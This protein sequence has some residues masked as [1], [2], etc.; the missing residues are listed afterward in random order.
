MTNDHFFTRSRWLSAL[1]IVFILTLH[2]M[3]SP[4]LA[5][6]QQDPVIAGVNATATGST[7]I[8]VSALLTNPDSVSATVY[9]RYKEGDGDWE[10]T[11]SATTSGTSATFSALT[12]LKPN[13]SY[14]IQVALEE[15]DSAFASNSA[16]V[17]TKQASLGS[18]SVSASANGTTAGTVAVT[19]SF[20]HSGV[21]VY[22]QHKARSASWPTDNATNRQ[23]KAPTTTGASEVLSFS[24]TG[25]THSTQYDVRASLA[26]DFSSGVITDD[27]TTATPA[28]TITGV[29]D[30][31]VT[32]NSAKITVSVSNPSSTEVYARYKE[33]SKADSTYTA[34]TSKPTTTTGS[35][36]DVVFSLSG[37]SDETGYTVQASLASDYSGA[38][39]DTFTTLKTPPSITSVGETAYDHNSATITVSVS[40]PNGTTV[41]LQ[42]KLNTASWPA[43]DSDQISTNRQS[44]PTQT[45]NAT[46]NLVFSITGLTAN[47]DYDVRVSFVADFSSGVSTDSFKTRMTPAISGMSIGSIAY[48]SATATVSLNNAHN[49]TVYVRHKVKGAA[50][51]TYVSTSQT[52]SASSAAFTL[53]NGVSPGKTYVVQTSLVSGYGSGV[54]EREFT[55]PGISSVSVSDIEYD[56]VKATV[57]VSG[58]TTAHSSTTVYLQRKAS[59]ESSWSPSTPLQMNA[60]STNSSLEFT[61]T[62][63]TPGKTYTVRS[64][65]NTAFAAGLATSS[66]FT[67]PSI[68]SVTVSEVEHNGSKVTVTVAGMTANTEDTVVYLGYKDSDD[69]TYTSAGTATATSTD[70]SLEFTLSG[71]AAGENYTVIAAFNSAYTAGAATATFTT[72]SISS[73]TISSISHGGATATVAV[74]GMASNTE[75]TTVYLQFKA[76]DEVSWSPSTP[77]QIDATSSDS[78]LEYTLTGLTAGK[79]YTV[80]AAFN[81]GFTVSLQSTTFT[82]P[83]ISSVSVSDRTHKSAKVT[84]AVA[85]MTANTNNTT[86]YFQHQ[87][88]GAATWTP[89][90]P[91]SMTATSSAASLEFPLSGLTAG[92]TYNVR[93]AFN[94][95]FSISLQ[96]AAF[97]TPNLSIA[98]PASDITHEAAKVRVTVSNPDTTNNTAVYLQYKKTADT[99]FIS[100]GSLSATSSSPTVEFSLSSLRRFT[101]YDVQASFESAFPSGDFTKS[102][103]FKTLQ[104]FPD[105]PK[106]FSFDQTHHDQLVISWEAP[107][108]DGG[109][110]VTGYKVQWRQD[111]GS[112]SSS[113]QGAT[114]ADT[115][116]YSIEGLASNTAYQV[117]VL[118]VNAIGDTQSPPEYAKTTRQAPVVSAVSVPEGG[119]DKSKRTVATATVTLSHGDTR[120]DNQIFFR[121]AVDSTPT[122]ASATPGSWTNLTSQSVSGSTAN[123]TDDFSLTGLTG[124]THYVVQSSLD[125]S[126]AAGSFAEDRFRTGSVSPS[127][128]QNVEVVPGPVPRTLVVRWDAPAS[129]GGTP[130]LGYHVYWEQ[131]ETP[132]EFISDLTVGP[133][134]FER[135][136]STVGD[137]ERWYGWVFA[138]N[139]HYDA[140]NAP[141]EISPSS[142]RVLGQASVAPGVPVNFIVQSLNGAINV[143]WGAAPEFN[144]AVVDYKI[145]VRKTGSADEPTTV[146]ADKLDGEIL[147]FKTIDGF[148]NGTE[149]EVRVYAMD[150]VGRDGTPTRWV[151]VIPVGPIGVPASVTATA[152][153][154]KITVTWQAPPASAGDTP[155]GYT[156]EWKRNSD[157][158]WSE[159]RGATSPHEIAALDGGTTYN[160]RV[161][162]NVRLNDGSPSATINVVPFTHPDAPAIRVSPANEALVVSWPVPFNGGSPIKNY[163][164]QWTETGSEFGSTNEATVTSNSHRI[165]GLT[166]GAEYQVRAYAVNEQD[167]TSEPS[168][169]VT[170]TPSEIITPP[171]PPPSQTPGAPSS[172]LVTAGDE[173]LLVTWAIPSNTGTSAITGYVVQWTTGGGTFGDDEATTT[174]LEYTVTGLTNDTEYD[175]RV[176][177]VNSNGRGTPSAVQSETPAEDVP[178]SISAI[179]VPGDDITETEA[180]IEISIANNDDG[181]S[182]D[183]YLR[184]RIY[185]PLGD[186]SETLEDSS[187]AESVEFSLAD[188]TAN[189]EYEVQASLDDT[190]PTDDTA[191]A[192]FTTATT[193]PGAPQKV[194]VTPMNNSLVVKWEAPEDD[195]GAEITDYVVQWKSGEEEFSSDREA[196]V[197][198]ETLTYTIADLEN[199]VEYTV[200]VLAMNENG[201]SEPSDPATGTP[202]DTSTG[203]IESVSVESDGAT[204][205]NVS[206]VVLGADEDHPVTVYMRHRVKPTE[207]DEENATGNGMSQVQLASPQQE[208]TEWSE[209]QSVETTT[210]VAEFTI[211]DLVEDAVYEIQVSLEDTFVDEPSIYIE[212]FTPAKVPGAPENLVLMSGDAEIIAKWTAP[213]D[214]G[215]SPVTGYIVRWKSGTEDFDAARQADVAVDDLMHTITGLENGTE[216]D[217]VVV[218]VNIIGESEPSA[219][220]SATPT[221]EV[222]TTVVRVR[223]LD[224][225]QT[226]ANVEVTLAN[227]D[228]SVVTTVHLRYRAV[229]GQQSWTEATPTAAT[230]DVL[231]FALIGLTPNTQYEVQASLD[232]T[233][234]VDAVKS[235]TFNTQSVPQ[236]PRITS[237]S[238]FSVNEGETRV[239]TLT[240][241]DADTPT[242]QLVWSILPSS[243]DGGNFM[244]SGSGALFFRSAK[245]FENPDDA[246]RDGTYELT[247]QVSDGQNTDTAMIRVTL[248]DV[249]E[250]T[251][252]PTPSPTPRPSPTPGPTPSPTPT[253]TP[254]P[255]AL[256][257]FA[258]ASQTVSEGGRISITVRLSSAARKLLA[259]P[260]RIVAGGTAEAGDYRISGLANGALSFNIGQSVKAF[261]FAASEDAD[262]NNE[263]VRLGFGALPEGVSAG[264]QR[265][266]TVT[267]IDNDVPVTGGGSGGSSISRRN[268]PP[269]FVERYNAVRSVAENTPAGTPVGDPVAAN[270]PDS[271]DQNSLNYTIAGVDVESFSIESTSGQILTK[272]ELNFETKSEYRVV[273]LV[274]DGR[275]GK[276]SISVTIHVTDINEPPVILGDA[277]ID[278]IENST[279]PVGS[280]TAS[281]PEGETDL[282][283]S[284][285]GDDSHLFSIGG[286]GTLRFESAPDFES[287]AD[288]DGDNVYAVT[289]QS[290][291]ELGVG[292]LHIAISVTDADDVGTVTLSADLP[293]VGSELN[294]RLEEQDGGVADIIWQWERSV[295]GSTWSSIPGAGSSSYTPV[296]S[297][298]G[299]HLRAIV[300]YKD[301]HGP[302]KVATAMVTSVVQEGPTATPTPVP[303]REPAPVP[304]VAPT[305]VPAAVPTPVPTV[306]PDAPTATPTATPVSAPVSMPA[307]PPTATPVVPAPV[308]AVQ[309]TATAVPATAVPIAPTPPTG[310]MPGSADEPT[311]ESVEVGPGVAPGLVIAL[312]VAAIVVVAIT[313]FVVASRRR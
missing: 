224:A 155:T 70:S 197:D 127:V 48:N 65:F 290:S 177:A 283:W 153:Q 82:T 302:D 207:E 67:T 24:L 299:R 287:A 221:E 196:K 79:T 202:S 109:A 17:I 26:D 61:L 40:N 43:S 295:D 260:V 201:L 113:A 116:E 247:V 45:T 58:L 57:A 198:D 50:D 267:I 274:R 130:I 313:A 279:A 51:S 172:V 115:L 63:L 72:P 62:G 77:L 278:H 219:I 252:T 124:N 271:R 91:L 203:M 245:D 294:A 148:E 73:V 129:D 154:E 192:K 38:S 169:V 27:F 8:T 89:A 98:I 25:L 106:N 216:Y 261:M 49:T 307:A 142:P 262:T 36:E 305:S 173:E 23:S 94:A 187:S 312:V 215:G 11:T 286:S 74:A 28:P 165:T 277:S 137:Q 150:A 168:S 250:V 33:S 157:T 144:S 212:E 269:R 285:S 68:S 3:E 117:R 214:D 133:S 171:P 310:T 304:T 248:L 225:A 111:A 81:T 18:G 162:A 175:V 107:D 180:N 303:T 145:Q 185:T 135:Q 122:G 87:E 210:G 259:I 114:T 209:V 103:T 205:A 97:V 288:A 108:D 15:T 270:D 37:L 39:T 134:T 227:R 301:V 208:E 55:T 22:L 146:S 263:T 181:A 296:E 141:E 93:A 143:S 161:F 53:T 128:P 164:V 131:D 243:P 229:T 69:T 308:P 249:E 136:F 166:N 291:D 240:A 156:V 60:T 211:T 112:Y 7:T 200:Q 174:D 275:G 218:A 226:T 5:F 206:V 66:A 244:V 86:V 140:T 132:G 281:D 191:S 96:G 272:A 21:T 30:S 233:F 56:A 255:A 230:S 118:A 149:Y 176:I 184:Y 42:H 75:D 41:Y 35:S 121:Y 189:T 306:T 298:E 246:N 268:G 159:A 193:V 297:D 167:L 95:T 253:P 223:I 76:S 14:T 235:L 126:Y 241:T 123:V 183:I 190:F 284:L 178:P 92:K 100:A 237:A 273:L 251:P 158:Q 282:S 32:H 300:S 99:T 59:D 90:T 188:L 20:P 85:G 78:S 213:D 102:G 10:S 52:T 110:T 54:T 47:T 16:T 138:Y 234:P 217:V 6:A 31:E 1:A 125:S 80:R 199:D 293:R 29:A 101:D 170:G 236:P 264:S 64:A 120:V 194:V 12:N 88:S 179:S 84:V 311:E 276:D 231:E 119:D 228:E 204:T 160:V 258:A 44:K 309:P 9:M 220:E 195:G 182:L 104:T 186:W 265:M 280:F 151:K 238:A 239:A 289:V 232:A 34:L 257:N 147:F 4:P 46:E 105:P 256:V 152:G 292:T 254:T 266:T 83:S 13:T 163:I 139:L 71:L 2:L 222:V 242:S 19:V